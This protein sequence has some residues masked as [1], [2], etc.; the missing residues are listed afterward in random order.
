[1]PENFPASSA[2]HKTIIRKSCRAPAL[3]KWKGTSRAIGNC[4]ASSAKGCKIIAPLCAFWISNPEVKASHYPSASGNVRPQT[5]DELSQ[6]IWPWGS[7][8]PGAA[9]NAQ[10]PLNVFRITMGLLALLQQKHPPRSASTQLFQSRLIRL[11]VALYVHLKTSTTL[12]VPICDGEMTTPRWSPSRSESP[13]TTQRDEKTPS[14]SGTRITLTPECLS[15]AVLITFKKKLEQTWF[16][17]RTIEPFS[18]IAP[19]RLAISGAH[20]GRENFIVS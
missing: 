8:Q 12:A 3:P 15:A 9:T 4:Y 11:H 7:G 20:K 5:E 17:Y 6:K 10:R 14:R 2:R 13:K 19:K 1:M 18:A 16:E